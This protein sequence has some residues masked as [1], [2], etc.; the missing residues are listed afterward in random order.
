MILFGSPT[1]PFVRRVR[2]VCLELGLPFE[3]VNIQQDE[4]HARMEA[5]TPLWKVPTVIHDDGR[6]QWDSEAIIQTLVGRHGLGPF[7]PAGDPLHEGNVHHAIYGALD[8][9]I[10][11]FYLRREGVDVAGIPYM[12]TQQERVGS[13]LEWVAEQLEGDS[14]APE[15]GFGLLELSLY[16]ALG[17]MAFRSVY[18]VRDVPVFRDFLDAHAVRPSLAATRPDLPFSG[19]GGDPAA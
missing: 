6:V 10:N 15:G 11:V 8:S 7:R 17:W 1:S 9:A 18:P 12:V 3:P 19:F 13:A 5:T 14:F 4:G 2:V 16:C